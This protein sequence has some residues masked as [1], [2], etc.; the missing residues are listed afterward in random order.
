MKIFAMSDIHGSPMEFEEAL[1][2]V[3]LSGDNMLILCGDYVHGYDSY[4][5][6]DR[7]ISLQEE[8]GSEKVVA[9]MGNHEEMAV[10]GMW[11]ITEHEEIECDEVKEDRYI[12]W[13]YNLPRY[14]TTD[15]QIFCH[16]GV[17]EDAGEEWEWGTDEFTFTEKYPAQTGKFCMDIIAGHVGTSEIAQN[18]RFHD[19]YF[20]GQSHYY[21]DGSVRDSGE[22]PV[23]MYDTET[24]LYYR[25]TANGEYPVVP[26][27]DEY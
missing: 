4:S 22:I 12:S 15:T 6:L 13:M 2:L 23:L 26:Y 24:M 18:P 5:V 16:A 8:Y 20:D 14:Y 27:D 10:D 21:I 19:I 3:D 9:L 11:H 17:E 25:M 1:S 7:I